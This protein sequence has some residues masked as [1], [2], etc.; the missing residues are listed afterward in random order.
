MA[1]AEGSHSRLT[2]AKGNRVPRTC[3]VALIIT[4]WL[5]SIL[6]DV[7]WWDASQTESLSDSPP[8][9]SGLILTL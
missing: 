1:R 8:Y 7:E 2:T 4:S 5:L 3:E 9:N 6:L